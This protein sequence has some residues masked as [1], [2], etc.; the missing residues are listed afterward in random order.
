M[1]RYYHDIEVHN[2]EAPKEI[3]P[4]IF[5]M[6]RPKSVVDVGC[7]LGTF[8][9]V[10]SDCGVNEIMGFDGEW[11]NDKKLNISKENI[12]IV[13]LE[14]PDW[15]SGNYDLAISLEVAEHLDSSIEEVFIKNLTSLSEV[16]VFSAALEGQGGQNHINEKP[17][18]SWI[19][20][21]NNFGYHF[22]DVFRAQFWNSKEIN[23]WYKQNMFLVIKK[24]SK[25]FDCFSQYSMDLD[26]MSF[27]HPDCLK[28]KFEFNQILKKEYEKLSKVKAYDI[29]YIFRQKL[30]SFFIFWNS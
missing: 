14:S 25:W 26:I 15:A 3:V 19:K 22:F 17:L 18:E 9:K 29:R 8:L 24:D 5:D 6:F 10:F 28:Q 16:I 27:V 4:I 30:K 20:I 11:L 12:R 13:D 7:G 23:W 1:V 21:F 2:L